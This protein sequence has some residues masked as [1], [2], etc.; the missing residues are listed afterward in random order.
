MTVAKIDADVA[1]YR[2]L[3]AGGKA[4]NATLAAFEATFFNNMV[5]ILDALFVHRLRTIDGED[6][7]PLNEVRVL[8][9]SPR[10][11]AAPLGEMSRVLRGS[12]GAPAARASGDVALT[13]L[14]CNF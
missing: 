13:H 8:C 4:S 2:S 9:N 12:R 11:G 3:G 5:I 1:A 14:G 6:G 7:N 10:R